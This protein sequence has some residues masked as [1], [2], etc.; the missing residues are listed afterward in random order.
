MNSNV[1][2]R[3]VG[4]KRSYYAAIMIIFV[5]LLCVSIVASLVFGSRSVTLDDLMAGLFLSSSD[6]Y[7]AA[8]VSERIPRTVF[9]LLCGG[10]LGVSGA[11]M[12]AVTRNPLADP[13]ILGVNTGASL[14]VV[15]GIAFFNI[16]TAGQYIWLSIVGAILTAIIVYGIGSMG[17]T[18]NTPLKLVLAG[19]A[20]SAILSSLISA[21]ML[22]RSFVMDQF[23]FWQV[24]SVGAANWDF[25]VIFLPFLVSGILLAF[26]M[27]PSLNALLLGDEIATGQGVRTG[28]LTLLS[29]FTGVILCGAVTALAGP[30][31]FI[32]LL[33]THLMR[34]IFGPD[35]RLIIPM[36]AIS[37][38]AILT[39]ADVLGRLI[40]SPG[41]VEAGIITAFI[42]APVLILLATKLKVRSL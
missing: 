40:G 14:F 5:L 42:G 16:S 13:S 12:Q 25:I 23:R 33:A 29:A 7:A 38:A 34:L 11:L 4:H 22:P 30:I 20:T 28:L 24:G 39:M 32:G 8:V 6:S 3:S 10:A 1:A 27:A 31:G 21:I 17:R 35:L 9:S 2:K 37:G 18:G 36:S 26:I 41:E 19:A 15:I